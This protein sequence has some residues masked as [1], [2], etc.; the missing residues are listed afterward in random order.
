MSDAQP[1]HL[2][3]KALAIIQARSSSSGEVDF[4]KVKAL[5]SKLLDKAGNDPRV[6][7][8]VLRGKVEERMNLE[9]SA[10]KPFRYSYRCTRIYLELAISRSLSSLLCCSILS[11]LRSPLSALLYCV[12][13]LLL[14]LS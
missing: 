6:T 5:I 4:E 3:T 11:T 7:P 1:A 14:S 13:L 10:L 8:R 9:P 2:S 12:L